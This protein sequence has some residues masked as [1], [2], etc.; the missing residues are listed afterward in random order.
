ML[1]ATQMAEVARWS[2]AELA[3]LDADHAPAIIKVEAGPG[4]EVEDA[5]KP[6]TTLAEA[7]AHSV[8]EMARYEAGH[9]ADRVQ[10]G[11]RF[12]DRQLRGGFHSGEL[13]LLGAPS[14]G[15]KSSLVQQ[16]ASEVSRRGPVLFV[17][18]EMGLIEL[19]EREII[20][21]SGRPLWDR[22]PW[23]DT[24]GAKEFARLA[25]EAAADQMISEGLPLYVLDHD[26]SMDEIEAYARSIAGLRL[27][28]I[29]YAQQVANTDPRTPRY[30]AVGEVG[31]RSVAL[32]LTLKIPVMVASQVN[33]S[34]E[35]KSTSYTFRETAI[36]EHKAHNV[37]IFEVKWKEGQGFREVEEAA[38]VCTKQRSGK[39]FRLSVRYEPELY[40]ISDIGKGVAIAEPG[41]EQLGGGW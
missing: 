13:T 22:N 33:V 23:T 19:A 26:C 12:L 14:G 41:L 16:I 4:L 20:R 2:R 21:R 7:G 9:F 17:S 10:T 8:A 39:L 30:L 31:S 40:R 15:G 34:T 29:D 25:H 5:L 11:I 18:P 1:S 35:G 38:I 24:G 6:L 37:L 36:L 32:A 27:L 3:R 28:V